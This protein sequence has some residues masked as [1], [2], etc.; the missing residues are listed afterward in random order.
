MLPSVAVSKIMTKEELTHYILEL[1]S[2]L[3]EQITLTEQEAT[4]K[5]AVIANR[6]RVLLAKQFLHHES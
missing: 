1:Q 4:I 5:L 3:L 6:Q 2:A